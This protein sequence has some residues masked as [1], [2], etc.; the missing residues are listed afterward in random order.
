[1]HR[2][3]TAL[4]S[5]G[6]YSHQEGKLLVVVARKQQLNEIKAVV[7]S[8]DKHAFISVSSAMS[9]YGKGFESVKN[10]SKQANQSNKINKAFSKWIK[11]HYF[12]L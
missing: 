7:M 1:M 12:R 11:E 10:L 6:W 3:V 2:G 4:H 5:E 8:V 9:V